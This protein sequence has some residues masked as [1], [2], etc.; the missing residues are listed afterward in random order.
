MAQGDYQALA[1]LAAEEPRLARLKVRSLLVHVSLSA[2]V[3]LFISLPNLK[4][5][6]AFPRE[7][8]PAYRRTRVVPLSCVDRCFPAALISSIFLS[9]I[10]T[11][12]CGQ[13]YIIAVFC[14]RY[15]LLPVRERNVGARSSSGAGC[16]NSRL[17]R[18]LSRQA[19]YR[20]GRR[21]A[22]ISLNYGQ[23]G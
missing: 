18:R 13:I 9:R 5:T 14:P 12:L 2:F 17:P 8:R 4:S 23:L 11:N 16:G 1:K 19:R 15:S 21:S 22:W 20:T 7:G 10:C 6:G 3:P